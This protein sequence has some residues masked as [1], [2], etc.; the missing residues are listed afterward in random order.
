LG[1]LHAASLP[2]LHLGNGP[3]LLLPSP[4]S[5]IHARA[6]LGGRG[7]CPCTVII[8]VPL[9]SLG[10]LAPPPLPVEAEDVHCWV[11]SLMPTLVVEVVQVEGGCHRWSFLLRSCGS[12]RWGIEEDKEGTVALNGSES[13]GGEIRRGRE[14]ESTEEIRTSTLFCPLAL[15]FQFFWSTNR[16]PCIMC[17]KFLDSPVMFSLLVLVSLLVMDVLSDRHKKYSFFVPVA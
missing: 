16:R 7:R 5:Q 12:G 6:P 10:L 11:E 1:S 2:S 13:R 3:L 14:R 4:H 9:S 8:V 17:S 15:V